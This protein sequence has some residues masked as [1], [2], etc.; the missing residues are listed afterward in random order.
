M[1]RVD[2]EALAAA[3]KLTGR[4]DAI[5]QATAEARSIDNGVRLADQA[6]GADD[7]QFLQSINPD[8]P[9]TDPRL[10][11]YARVTTQDWTVYPTFVRPISDATVTARATA[12]ASRWPAVCV[13]IRVVLCVSADPAVGD[14]VQIDTSGGSAPVTNGSP[15]RMLSPLGGCSWP[16]VVLQG[17]QS[18]PPKPTENAAL[19]DCDAW[20]GVIVNSTTPAPVWRYAI[21]NVP[22]GQTSNYSATVTAVS[23]D[24]IYPLVRLV[25]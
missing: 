2:A 19:I 12:L 9:T 15:G 25:R 17:A 21:L 6:G 18:P 13:P 14:T 23:A 1:D 20:G 7:L 22:A 10:A 11:V 5:G 3:A 24:K 8:Q 16:G 4:P